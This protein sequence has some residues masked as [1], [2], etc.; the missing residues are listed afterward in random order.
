MKVQW[1]GDN[2]AEV[3]QFITEVNAVFPPTDGQGVRAVFRDLGTPWPKMFL[4]FVD[5]ADPA[6]AP[7]STDVPLSWWVTVDGQGNLVIAS[8]EPA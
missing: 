7:L 6:G 2:R 1:T 8:A 5:P 4:N 3:E